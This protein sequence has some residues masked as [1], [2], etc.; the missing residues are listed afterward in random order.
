MAQ[1]YPPPPEGPTHHRNTSAAWIA[2]LVLIVIGAVF[3]LQNLNLLGSIPLLQNWWAL[4]ILIPAVGAFYRVWQDI[5]TN[6]RLTGV[7]RGSLI[8][9]LF[10]GFLSAVF[11][12]DLNWGVIW[13]I[14]I[15]IAGIGAFLGVIFR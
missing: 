6:G 12:F 10:M 2:G 1:D 4:F 3:L 14:F 15:I 7:G 5:Q 8:S 9:G 13:P 11:L